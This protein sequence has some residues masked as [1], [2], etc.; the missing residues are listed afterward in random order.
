MYIKYEN[1]YVVSYVRVLIYLL[2]FGVFLVDVYTQGDG[3]LYVFA[4][5]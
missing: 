1:V 5:Y 3:K 2:T 4:F